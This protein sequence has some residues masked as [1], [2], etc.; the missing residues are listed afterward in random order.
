M[1]FEVA[2]RFS[3]CC[4]EIALNHPPIDTFALTGSR[5][6]AEFMSATA[7]AIVGNIRNGLKE[8]ID[9]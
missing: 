1:A 5:S 6:T 7:H 2:R 3:V 8:G 9:W 4:V